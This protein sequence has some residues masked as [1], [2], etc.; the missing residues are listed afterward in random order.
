MNRKRAAQNIETKIKDWLKNSQLPEEYIDSVIVTGGA[1][2]S[3]LTDTEVNDYD[4]Y[5]TD[6]NRLE[7]VAQLY[8]RIYKENAPSQLL[9]GLGEP[10]K[11]EVI[12][13]PDRIVLDIAITDN[14]LEGLIGEEFEELLKRQLADRTPKED[15]PL[16]RP[17]YCSKNAITLSDKIQIILRFCG[18]PDEI[19]KNFDFA[20]CMGYWTKETGLIIS[21][22]TLSCILAK[23][24]LYR[25]SLYPLAS[26]F[27]T[28]KFIQRGW[29]I[30]VGQYVKMA[31]QIAELDLLDKEVLSEQL[32]GVDTALWLG[33]IDKIKE[34]DGDRVDK[35]K[36]LSWIDEVF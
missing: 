11:I 27:R 1:I 24:L 12:K 32:T 21:E 9:N 26:I 17:V 19:H 7:K 30:T 35:V 22:E 36:L 31:L 13:K 20:H 8:S 25:G 23:E 14:P 16:Y 4:I 6:I 10:P 2:V 29:T 15:R 3:L 28:R 5:F 34:G 18:R 33:V